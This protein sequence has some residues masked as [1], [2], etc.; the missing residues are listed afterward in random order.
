MRLVF[1]PRAYRCTRTFTG[2]TRVRV[3]V[4]R[5]DR[6]R[7]SHNTILS[8][9]LSPILAVNTTHPSPSPPLPLPLPLLLHLSPSPARLHTLLPRLPPPYQSQHLVEWRIYPL[10]VGPRL[11]LLEEAPGA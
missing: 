8:Y 4:R 5:M 10:S 6:L 2:R 11:T 1:G 3:S 9:S 7:I